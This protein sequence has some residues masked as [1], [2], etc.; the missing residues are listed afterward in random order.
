LYIN[1][2]VRTLL[3]ISVQSLHVQSWHV[4]QTCTEAGGSMQVE[5]TSTQGM[6]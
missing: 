2:D 3:T 5:T 4:M 6:A 1:S